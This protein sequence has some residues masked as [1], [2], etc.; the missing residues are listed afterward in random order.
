MKKYILYAF[1]LLSLSS[2]AQQWEWAIQESV[3]KLAVDS[4]GNAFT[5]NDSTIKKFDSNGTLLW[6]KQFIGDLLVR[7]LAADNAGNFYITG[8]F[9]SFFIDNYHFTSN[10]NKDVFL[11]K[12][13]LSGTLLWNKIIGGTGN[14]NVTDLF[15][16]KNQKILICGTAGTGTIIGTT[17]FSEP[18]LFTIR[19]DLNGNQES[20][21]NHAGGEAWE[22][23]ADAIGNI[24]LL[25]GININDTLDF[26]NGVT[27]NGLPAL[28]PFGTHFMAIFDVLG[29]ILWANDM[30]SNSMSLSE[31]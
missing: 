21:L 2:V 5:Q 30:G 20:L 13:N 29:N 18:A 10:G 17:F 11:G 3:Q 31:R 28:D 23:S 12:F 7:G 27:L 15:A 8:V 22:V 19:Y 6:Q 16:T 26:G 4:V 14:E 25:G 9:T 24:Y 1:C